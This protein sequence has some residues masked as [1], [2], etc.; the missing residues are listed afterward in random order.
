MS[1]ELS[2]S[3]NPI[4]RYQ[5]PEKGEWVP[6]DKSGSSMEAIGQHIEAHIGKVENVFHEILSHIVHVDIHIVAP[7]P[8][9]PY[10]TL[11]T[12]GMS[13]LPMSP[14]KGAE[15]S[16]FAELMLCLPSSWPMGDEAWEIKENYWPIRLLKML[17]RFPHEYKT[18]L[19]FGHTMPNGNPPEPFASNTLTSCMM[20]ARPVTVSTTFWTLQAGE[21]K[22]IN[23]FS[24]LPLFP[25][26]QELKL[27]KGANVII[28]RF[29]KAKYSELIDLSRKSVATN[30]WWRVF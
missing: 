5:T 19:W 23:F 3:G 7:T 16:R 12:S 8:E 17:A 14:P 25:D 20:L 1:E 15:E 22:T 21:D 24:I 4:Y 26:E 28:E 27:K 9:R 13:D 2:E 11:V 29:E 30:P 10:H 18:W 6:P